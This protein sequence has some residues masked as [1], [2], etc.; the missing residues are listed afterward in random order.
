MPDMS[1]AELAKRL[2]LAEAALGRIRSSRAVRW[3]RAAREAQRRVTGVPVELISLATQAVRRRAP[4]RA[5]ADS[6]TGTS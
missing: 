6:P 4:R 1:P 3:T 5:D 2:Q